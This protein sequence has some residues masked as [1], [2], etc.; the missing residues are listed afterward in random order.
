MNKNNNI[1]ILTL[2]L[3]TIIFHITLN[4]NAQITR[5]TS[6]GEILIS[7]TWYYLGS[8]N[9]YDAIFYSSDYG[10]SIVVQYVFN[11]GSNNMPVGK[12]TSDAL[13]GT[14]YNNVEELWISNNNGINWSFVEDIGIDKR[15]ASGCSEGEIY[16]YCKNT[17]SKLYRSI[18]FGQNFQEINNGLFGFPEVGTL[19]GEIY[20]LAGSTWPTFN[21]ELLYSSNYGS[22]FDTISIDPI[23]QGYYLEGNFPIISRGSGT[24][25]IYLVS[26]HLP[27]NYYIYYSNDNGHEFS[28][29][30][31]SNECNFF[32]EN[33]Y[34]TAG[35]TPG[36][37]YVIK[38][39]PWYDGINTQL[40]IYHSEDTAQNFTVYYHILDEATPVTAVESKIL[41]PISL[42]CY[43]N[44]FS[45]K[46]IFSFRIPEN[47]QT[48]TLN[49]FNLEGNLEIQF[50]IKCTNQKVW[51]RRGKNE[52]L[53]PNGLYLYNITSGSTA[54]QFNKLLIIH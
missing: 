1:T 31:F 33:Y 52:Q 34:F 42:T 47:W 5:G 48:P 24:G 45:E 3:L 41:I 26:W 32:Y 17:E 2:T 43:P 40:E 21:I 16:K 7:S 51:N 4:L 8:Q 23:I 46:T 12:L 29:K 15:Y 22:N 11:V 10:N 38:Q 54:S 37:F 28:L 39:I 27:A 14:Y 6:P 25:E 36:E 49:I 53:L 20:L 44:P 9:N 19:E 35:I 18:D 50:N 13:S 30:Y